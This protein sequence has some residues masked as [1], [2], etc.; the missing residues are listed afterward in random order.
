[1]K[2]TTYTDFGI[3]TLMYLATLPKGTR[4]SSAD[5]ANIYQASRNHIAKVIAHLSSLNYI[6]SSR[7]KNGGIWLTRAAHE[8]NIGQLIRELEG[9]L[10]GVDCEATNCSLVP[11]CQLKKALKTGVEAF[12]VAL[13]QYY[14]SDFLTNSEELES[15]W[16]VNLP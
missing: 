11:V 3:R 2:L 5:V 14:L 13:D 9:N 15:L 1:M 7:G 6:D 4:S 16:Y 12:L 8:I 10:E